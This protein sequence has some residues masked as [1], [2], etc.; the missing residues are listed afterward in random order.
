MAATLWTPNIQ[1]S[2]EKVHKTGNKAFFEKI[3]EETYKEDFLGGNSL[4]LEFSTFKSFFTHL[5]LK[6]R[7]A[8]CPP[9]QVKGLKH[10][11]SENL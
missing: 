7:G 2:L 3:P 10:Q 4:F 5:P 8:N 1:L 11:L 9:P 6:Q